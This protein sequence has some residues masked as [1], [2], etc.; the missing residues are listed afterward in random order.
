MDA[1]SAPNALVKSRIGLAAGL[2]A[3]AFSVIVARLVEVMVFGAS[4]AGVAAA[5][6]SRPPMRA[7]FVDRN[8]VLIARDLPVSDLYASPA[9]FWDADEAANGLAKVTGADAMRLKELFAEKRGYVLVRRGLSPD[10]RDGVMRL[11]LPGLTFEKSY[12]R[13]YPAGRILSH[14]VG[15]VDPD[16]NGVSGLEL[17]LDNQVRGRDKPLELSFDMRVQYVLEHEMRETV[18]AFTA[19]AAG[20]LV[21]DVRTGEVLALASLPTYEP[22]SR[23]LVP[24]D[25]IRNRLTQ[26]VYEL[27]SIFKIF[28][29]SQA[30]EEKTVSLS[31]SINIGK[32]LKFGRHTINDF[33]NHGSILTASMVFAES[34][35]IGTAQIALR[36][37][38]ARQQAFLR[39][40]GLLDGLKTEL[41]EMASPLYPRRWNEVETVTI[42]YGQGISVNPLAFAAAAAAAVN[43]G[44]LIHPTFLKNPTPQKGERVIS[45]ATSQSMR[46]L[47]RLVV[48]QGTGRKADVPGYEVGGKTGTADKPVNGSYGR[49]LVVSS[50]AGVFPIS[51]PQY[52]VFVMIDEPKG[53]KASF[54]FATGGWTAAPAV[55]R[56]ISRIAPL[57]GVRRNDTF[58]AANP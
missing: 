23:S 58:A 37:G 9:A 18:R 8:G 22:N 36:A 19:K 28:A 40:M 31:E 21:L 33:D 54:G 30:I 17:G 47:M 24:G 15:Q 20:G 4:V 41:P 48:T 16:D 35:N 51:Q 55:G 29:F 27:G 38:P 32:P 13:Y 45:E 1:R 2:C 34:S 50:F 12:R 53:N 46:E 25:S 49:H 39:R 3:A 44:T 52:L 43:G 42:S 11:G 26:D 14:A 10:V 57:L 7:D 6:P 5:E 56:V